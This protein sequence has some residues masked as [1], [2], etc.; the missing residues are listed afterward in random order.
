MC[1]SVVCPRCHNEYTTRTIKQHLRACERVPKAEEL[2]QLLDQ[3]PELSARGL[4]IEYD[5]THDFI[6]QRLQGTRWDRARLGKRGRNCQSLRQVKRLRP[7]CAAPRCSR[8]EVLLA[9]SDLSWAVTQLGELCG[10]CIYELKVI[11]QRLIDRP[12]W[13]ANKVDRELLRRWIPQQ[14]ELI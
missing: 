9:E 7:T 6:Y 5:T 11:A 4:S 10:H 12:A 13:V 2:C 1:K 8:C 3:R 14:M